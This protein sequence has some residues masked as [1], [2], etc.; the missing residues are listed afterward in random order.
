MPALFG[1][2]RAMTR[3]PEGLLLMRV[4]GEPLP[5]GT[6]TAIFQL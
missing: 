6:K 3:V 2:R 5:E 4:T 1:T